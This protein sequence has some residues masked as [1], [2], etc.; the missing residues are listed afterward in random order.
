MRRIGRT[1]R[2]MTGHLEGEILLNCCACSSIDGVRSS[3]IGL[4][5][6]LANGRDKDHLLLG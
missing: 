5:P 2:I 6:H 3:D 1:I 4:H